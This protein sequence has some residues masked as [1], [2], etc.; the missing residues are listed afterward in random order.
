[1]SA[2]L[3][4]CPFCGGEAKLWIQISDGDEDFGVVEC[5]QCGITQCVA[6]PVADAVECW[7]ARAGDACRNADE[8]R[9]FTCS[10]CG[11]RF[12]VL[13]QGG[14]PTEGWRFVGTP[15]H[16]PGCGAEVEG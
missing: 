5:P 10:G 14:D 13:A 4:A 9:E 15:R 11:G 7:N 3:K 16:C 1:M 6:D 2:D 12:H 8:G